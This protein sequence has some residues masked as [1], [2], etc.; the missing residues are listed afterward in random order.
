MDMA[1]RLSAINEGN[2]LVPPCREPHSYAFFAHE[3]AATSAEVAG[4]H[5]LAKESDSERMTSGVLARSSAER[6]AG[7]SNRSSS[8]SATPQSRQANAISTQTR[9]SS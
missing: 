3:G 7:I 9:N 1:I 5:P 8:C 2:S 4:S 6:T